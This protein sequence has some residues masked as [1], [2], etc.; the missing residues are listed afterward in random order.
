MGGV[1][2]ETVLDG[3]QHEW[4]YEVDA[5]DGDRDCA[6]QL[7]ADPEFGGRT[8]CLEHHRDRNERHDGRLHVRHRDRVQQDLNLEKDCTT[9]GEGKGR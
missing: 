9:I 4:L 2:D 8:E 1:E 6:A 3:C 5:G 7:D